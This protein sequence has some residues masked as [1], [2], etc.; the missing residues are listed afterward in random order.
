[1]WSG[2]RNLSTAM[3]RSWENRSDTEVLDEPLYAAYLAAIGAARSMGAIVRATDPRPAT[4]EQVE[5]LGGEFLEVAVQDM[6]AV[7]IEAG[8]E[9]G[10]LARPFQRLTHR[11]RA[12]DIVVRPVEQQRRGPNFAE[13]H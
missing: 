1:M 12:D 4:R 6:P 11:L 10:P 5:S 8:P 2:P 9:S 13:P 3:M 7:R